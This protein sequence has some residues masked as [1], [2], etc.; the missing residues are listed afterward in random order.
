MKAFVAGII[1]LSLLVCAVC[2]NAFLII[3]KTDSLIECIESLPHSAKE[4]DEAEL[5]FQWRR[6]QKWIAL[7]VHRDNVDDIDDTLEQLSLEI[8][9]G[10]DHGYM[11]ART[12]LLCIM[13]RLKETESFSLKRIF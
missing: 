8:D 11:V 10:N 5:F 12:K 4:A 9:L 13:E 2:A 3:Q 6:S 1:T 7:T